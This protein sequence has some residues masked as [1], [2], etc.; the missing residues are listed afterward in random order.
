MNEI[1]A[2]ILL[3]LALE[4]IALGFVMRRRGFDG[5]VWTLLGLFLGPIA[6]VIALTHAV[7][8]PQRPVTVLRKGTGV[9]SGA[10]DVLVGYDGS[11]EAAAAVAR[12]RQLFGARIGR[13]AVARVTP[14]D[15]P[16]FDEKAAEASLAQ[17]VDLHPELHAAAVV[18]HGAPAKALMDYATRAGYGLVV[19]GSRGAGL[20][21]LIG[22]VASTLAHE[23]PV[24]VLLVDN[25][26]A[27]LPL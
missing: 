16:G 5:Y 26:P 12:V 7:R 21:K 15:A 11:P 4:A 19:V 9:G 24:P 18:L 23:S 20:S 27:V 1:P 14:I 10:L 13:V 6:V 3:G 25:E 22:S 17:M 2:Y 8:S